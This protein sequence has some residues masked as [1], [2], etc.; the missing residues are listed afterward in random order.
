MTAVTIGYRSGL[1]M[2]FVYW[3]LSVCI[4]TLSI[5]KASWQKRL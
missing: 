2:P 3:N 1:V 4:F 5:L